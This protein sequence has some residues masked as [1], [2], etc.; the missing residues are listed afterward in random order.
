MQKKKED[1]YKGKYHTLQDVKEQ[2][3][4]ILTKVIVDKSEYVIDKSIE[5]TERKLAELKQLKS[6]NNSITDPKQTSKSH[7]Q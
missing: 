7:H 1:F 5:R 6:Q 3:N 4:S 2:L